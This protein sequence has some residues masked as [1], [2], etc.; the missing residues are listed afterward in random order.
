MGIIIFFLKGTRLWKLN[1]M[2][3]SHMKWI[4]KW[5]PAKIWLIFFFEGSVFNTKYNYRTCSNFF[6]RIILKLSCHNKNILFLYFFY[7]Y[8]LYWRQRYH[9]FYVEAYSGWQMTINCH[10]FQSYLVHVM[11]YRVLYLF[12]FCPC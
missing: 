1:W 8:S 9:G 3:K 7:F 6:Q 12:S 10:R 11:C 2:S 4:M 5:I